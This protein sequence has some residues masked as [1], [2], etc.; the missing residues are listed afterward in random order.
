MI[1]HPDIESLRPIERR[2]LTMRSEGVSREEIGR[3]IRKSPEFVERVIDWTEI[4]RSGKTRDSYLSPIEARVLALT[5][6]GEDHETIGKRFNK[7]G[8]FIRQVLGMAHYRKGLRLMSGAATE[9]RD[10]YRSRA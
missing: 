3:R 4:P 6:E 8:R 7:S 5:A 9:A 1:D 10:A 2:I